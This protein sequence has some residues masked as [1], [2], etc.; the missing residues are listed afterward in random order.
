MLYGRPLPEDAVSPTL[1]QYYVLDDEDRIEDTPT[2]LSASYQWSDTTLTG[3]VTG[4]SSYCS[5]TGAEGVSGNNNLPCCYLLS[6][7]T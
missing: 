2:T 6:P 5:W 7:C 1:D 4:R 3:S